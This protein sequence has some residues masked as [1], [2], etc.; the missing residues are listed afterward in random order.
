MIFGDGFKRG[1]LRGLSSRTFDLLVSSLILV[2][3][4]PVML[5]TVLAVKLEDGFSAPVFF[6]QTRVGLGGQH[7]DMLK[8][9]SMRLD[10]ERDGSAV[11][12]QRR[13]PRA[14]RVG[15]LIR[16]MRVDELPQILNVVLGQM[17]F[18]GPR[19]ERPQFVEG[20]SE[21]IPYY[22][23]RHCVKPGITGWAQ[24]CYP[25]G[26]SEHDAIQKLQYD[27]YY[28]KNKT[29]LFDL[30]ILLQT[31]EVVIMGKGTR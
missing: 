15:A 20:F 1:P 14:T 4:L 13:D 5:L 26:S 28:I 21:R 19:P 23:S 24:L 8:F 3:S 17:S 18:V 25:Y 2:A 30:A 31:V 9:R 11:W 6:R 12:A 27:L 10:A 7:F 16:R 29:L 22:E